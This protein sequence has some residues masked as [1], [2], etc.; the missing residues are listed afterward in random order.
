MPTPLDF[1]RS[2][3]LSFE[4]GRTCEDC[5]ELGDEI[6]NL[7][8]SVFDYY[9]DLLRQGN[10]INDYKELTTEGAEFCRLVQDPEGW[11]LII[12]EVC[13][14]ALPTLYPIIKSAAM[15]LL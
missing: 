8:A 11:R 7:D 4:A 13:V 2:I 9:V 5:P 6:K 3:L 1:A 15:R 10:L 12:K 14:N